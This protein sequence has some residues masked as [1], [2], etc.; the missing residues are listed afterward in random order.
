MDHCSVRAHW[1][2]CG[3]PTAWQTELFPADL[4]ASSSTPSQAYSVRWLRCTTSCSRPTNML[5]DLHTFAR[6]LP[7]AANVLPHPHFPCLTKFFFRYS[8]DTSLV[9]VLQSTHVEWMAPIWGFHSNL[10]I[11][12]TLHCGWQFTFLIDR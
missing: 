8:N 2:W 3:K 6:A 10:F 1:N 11:L 12:F 4:L 7:S 9:T 5:S